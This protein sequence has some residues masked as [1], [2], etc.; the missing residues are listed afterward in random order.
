M[1]T[2]LTE[3]QKKYPNAQVWAFGDSPELADELVDLVLKGRKTATCSAASAY[4]NGE[5]AP[6]PGG[7]S[8]I[9]NGSGDPVCVIQTLSLTTLKF[10]QVSAEQAR[11]EGEGDL[12]LSY[13]RREHQIFFERNGE[14]SEEMP[15]IFEEF[16]LVERI[17][18]EESL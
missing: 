13:W 6:V 12:S 15:L 4:E 8:I 2:R 11:K 14:F 10:S 16:M 18:Q 7:Y 9:L 1:S 5:E 17:P 3:Y